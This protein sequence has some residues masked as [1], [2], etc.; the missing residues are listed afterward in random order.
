[1]DPD[2]VDSLEELFDMYNDQEQ[3]IK[4]VERCKKLG[5]KEGS[6]LDFLLGGYYGSSLYVYD[7]FSVNDGRDEAEFN[8]IVTSHIKD[9]KILF[10]QL[11]EKQH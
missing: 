3:I 9:L 1:M 5:E 6:C 10:H 8:K 4:I 11:Q 7:S 2:L